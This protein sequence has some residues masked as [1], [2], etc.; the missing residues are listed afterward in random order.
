M[1]ETKGGNGR[2][3]LGGFAIIQVKEEDGGSDQD[4]GRGGSD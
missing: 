3:Q 4:K 2:Q 1:Q